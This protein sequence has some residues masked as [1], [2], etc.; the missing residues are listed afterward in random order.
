[1][2]WRDHIET[3]PDRMMGKPVLK[4]TRL[5]VEIILDWLAAGWSEADLFENY[6]SLT[7]DG[8]R[9]IYA[10]ASE[11]VHDRAMAA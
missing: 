5:T 3:M 4:G 7:P 9:A 2:D 8:L 1:M 6:P 10:F 11:A